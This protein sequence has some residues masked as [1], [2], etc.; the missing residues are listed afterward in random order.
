MGNQQIIEHKKYKYIEDQKNAEAVAWAFINEKEIIQFPFIFP[1]L[2]DDEVRATVIY[3]GLCLCDSYYCRGLS[4]KAT[5]PVVPG[6]EVI[7]IISQKG[8]NVIDLEI[9]QKVGFSLIRDFCGKCFCCLSDRENLC[10][11]VM[12][13]DKCLL[14]DY[15]G[16]FATSIQ[17]PAKA[18]YK[19]PE[20]LNDKAAAPLFC[21][22]ISVYDP[23]AIHANPECY[24]CVMG[25]SDMGQL[26]IRILQ[27]KGVK[28]LAAS[29]IKEE[30]KSVKDEF[31]VE[32]VVYMQ[33]PEDLKKHANSV[34]LIINTSSDTSILNA[35]IG[36]CYQKATI[37]QVAVSEKVGFSSLSLLRKEIKLEGSFVGSRKHM[38]EML[39][40]CVDND[41]Y[42][43]V[44][45]F[46]F[47]DLPKAFDKLEK[48]AILSP[49]VINVEDWAKK[50]GFYNL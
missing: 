12:E 28:V 33:D 31:N 11:E 30:L 9:G 39:N 47:E 5:Y 37:V 24:T 50:N 25:L 3:T 13:S 27:K 10:S 6:H 17:Q 8:K 48:G 21:A 2:G 32:D 22:G 34:G 49:C 42:P 45:P 41:I 36:L 43:Q 7:A 44:E 20:K 26:A 4:G 1:K 15:F 19:L 16:G 18:A 46:K 38:D 35:L 14:G 23:I 29:S 40:F